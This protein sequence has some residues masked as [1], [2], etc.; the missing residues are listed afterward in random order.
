MM[1]TL[2]GR[3]LTMITPLFDTHCHLGHP[4]FKGDFKEATQRAF[5]AGVKGFA[6][7][8]ADQ[9]SL[10]RVPEVTRELKQHFPDGIFCF[11]SGM[12]PH[13]AKDVDENSWGLIE[14]LAMTEASAVGE[15]GLDFFYE[16]SDRKL[17]REVFRRHIDLACRVKKPL[18][19]HCRQA[20]PEVLEDLKSSPQINSH[21]RPG[22]LHCFTENWDFAREVLD[23]GFM[24]SLSGIITFKNAGEL[25]EVAKKVPLSQLL[26]ETDSPWLAPV[27]F[28]GKQNEPA[29]VREVAECLFSLRSESRDTVKEALW[30]NSCKIWGVDA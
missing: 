19:I 27:P 24:I 17:Q 30:K 6:L 25:R 12:H 8:S 5:A 9:E 18:V 11:S 3:V 16:H 21:P 23:L 7:I 15:A 28:R 2:R 29:Y 10:N 26:I 4:E 14:N 13:D 22:I 20:A 1:M